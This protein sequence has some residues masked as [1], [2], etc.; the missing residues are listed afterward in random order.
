MSTATAPRGQAQQQKPGAMAP[1][2]VK[3]TIDEAV[4][5]LDSIAADYGPEALAPLSIINR[6]LKL[7]RGIQLA[8]SL[9]TT[10]FPEVRHLAGT[11]LGFRTDQDKNGRCG[12]DDATIIECMTEASL[13]GFGWVG[14]EF[15]IISGKFYATKEGYTRKVRELPGLTDLSHHIGVPKGYDGGAIVPFKSKWKSNGVVMELERQ[16]PVRMNSGMGADGAIGKA[17]RKMLASIYAQETGSEKAHEDA[18]GEEP[19]QMLTAPAASP[20]AVDLRDRLLNGGLTPK[21]APPVDSGDPEKD[22]FKNGGQLFTQEPS[23]AATH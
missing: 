3:L 6:S 4:A 14:N 11:Q 12:Y 7:S 2:D 23:G 15:N 5:K 8:R 16:I 1:A 21:P 18:A 10:V 17:T 9:V 13:R 19:D 20:Q 22:P